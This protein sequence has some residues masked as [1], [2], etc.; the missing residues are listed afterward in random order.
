[1][2][3][4]IRVDDDVYRY[5]K[6]KAEPFVDTPNTVLRRELKLDV[7][8]AEDPT[9]PQPGVEAPPAHDRP[10]LRS[11]KGPRMPR[12]KLLPHS[13][14][15]QPILSAITDRGGAAPAADVIEAVGKVLKDDLTD[16]DRS[17]NPSGG[18]R[19]MNRTQW[20]RQR[21]VDDGLLAKDSPRGIWTITEAGRRRLEE[22][23]KGI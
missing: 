7:A 16:E 20:V 19:W 6:S 4:S 17:L 18:V 11:A 8:P 22:L 1:M 2:L 15:H 12:G 21:L 13:A 14:Y 9:S 3:P 10:R 5:L 23:T